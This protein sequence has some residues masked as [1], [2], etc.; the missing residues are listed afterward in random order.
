MK[1]IEVHHERIKSHFV[2][3]EKV[4]DVADSIEL[5]NKYGE[6]VSSFTIKYNQTDKYNYI[7]LDF[8]ITWNNASLFVRN[9]GYFK[10]QSQQDILNTISKYM[11]P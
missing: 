2:N 7:S 8:N 4:S 11:K 5:P 9:V 1:T 10:F 3:M 6:N